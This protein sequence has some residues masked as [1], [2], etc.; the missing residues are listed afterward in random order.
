MPIQSN[1]VAKN[2]VIASIA[3]SATVYTATLDLGGNFGAGVVFL[4]KRGTASAG[5]VLSIEF[6][7]DNTTFYP[8]TNYQL[9]GPAINSTSN[10]NMDVGGR[11]QGRYIRGKFVNGS[12]AQA[13]TAVLFLTSQPDD[14]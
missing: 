9:T 10:A 8:I 3:A 12:T 1:L 7:N 2:G 11:I 5:E 13:A 4:S 6:S 14:S